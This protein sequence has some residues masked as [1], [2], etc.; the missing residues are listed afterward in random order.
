MSLDHRKVKSI[1][2]SRVSYS[3][4]SSVFKIDLGHSS[5]CESMISDAQ[6]ISV[7]KQMENMIESSVLADRG[8]SKRQFPSVVSRQ[9]NPLCVVPNTFRRTKVYGDPLMLKNDHEYEMGDDDFIKTRPLLTK[10]HFSSSSSSLVHKK[11]PIISS[12]MSSQATHIRQKEENSNSGK[13]TS[14]LRMLYKE[15]EKNKEKDLKKLTQKE[16]A[17][18]LRALEL[19]SE[20]DNLR[21]EKKEMVNAFELMMEEY[22][23][24]FSIDT[25]LESLKLAKHKKE[26]SIDQLK[27]VVRNLYSTNGPFEKPA[28][29]SGRKSLGS[30]KLFEKIEETPR[31]GN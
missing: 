9:K 23:E 30:N 15:R 6:K 14:I 11:K 1:V 19:Q 28:S 27:Q 10:H 3:G 7:S 29:S 17:L 21:L 24:M 12:Q 25:R 22:K 16:S 18:Q 26:L 5:P 4:E 20:V 2:P 8:T 31:F 13:I